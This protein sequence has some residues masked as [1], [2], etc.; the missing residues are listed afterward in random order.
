VITGSNQSRGEFRAEWVLMTADPSFFDR[1][2]IATLA[3]PI[4][5]KPH[6]RLWTDDYSSLLPVLQTGGH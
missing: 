1:E 6:L 5:V 2:E 3:D 4:Y